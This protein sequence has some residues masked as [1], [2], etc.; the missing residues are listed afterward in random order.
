VGAG[1]GGD[2][3]PGSIPDGRMRCGPPPS[4]LL[5]LVC[6]IGRRQSACGI[7]ARGLDGRR[8]RAVVVAAAPSLRW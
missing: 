4:K 8:G 3:M 1:S 6:G 5:L 2:I 7:S